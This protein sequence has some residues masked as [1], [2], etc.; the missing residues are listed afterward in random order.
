MRKRYYLL[1]VSREANGELS[2]VPIPLHY[3]YTFLVGSLMG[4]MV[5]TGMAGSYGRMLVKTMKFNELRTEKEAIR[6]DYHQLEAVAQAKDEQVASMSMLASEVS[7]LYGLNARPVQGF[8]SA[9][10]EDVNASVTQFAELKHTAMSGST[11]LALLGARRHEVQVDDWYRMAAAPTLWP[12]EGV[13]TSSFGQRIDPF[14]GEG[15]FHKGVDISAP[16]GTP[17]VAPADGYVEK[18]G[19]MNGYG[20]CVILAHEHGTSTLYGHLSA[21]AVTEGQEVRRG[22][23]IGY[24]GMS[25]RSTGAHVHY[26]VRIHGTPVNPYTYLRQTA[27]ASLAV[28]TGL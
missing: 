18:A 4:M 3:V 22:E 16:Y 13:L 27:R 14:G 2:K 6:K 23:T 1:F 7:S 11:T 25:G 20:R 10:D 19:E 24:I 15:A 9:T 28:T 12:V 8:I 17:I 5:V 26:E 21:F